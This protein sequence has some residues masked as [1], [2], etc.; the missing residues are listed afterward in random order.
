MNTSERKLFL[1]NL[2]FMTAMFLLLLF[3]TACDKDEIKIEDASEIEVPPSISENNKIKTKYI[4]LNKS[5]IDELKIETIAIKKEITSHILSVPGFVFPAP[6]NI[7][8]ISAPLDGRVAKIYAHEGEH[9]KRGQILLELESYEYGNLV[10]EYLQANAEKVYQENKLTRIKLLVDKKISSM[11]DLDKAEAEFTRANAVLRGAYS[12]LKAVGTTENDINNL[13][14]STT[15]NSNLKIF[16]PLSGT[17]DQHLIEHGQ[18]V[19]AYDKMLSIIDLSKV[20]VRG[21]VSP[22]DGA[23]VKAGDKIKAAQKNNV[24]NFIEGNISTINPALDEINKSIVINAELNTKN[25][26]PK[27]GE[28]LKVEITV[29]SSSPEITIPLSS[30]AY[31]GDQSVVFVKASETKFEQRPIIIKKIYAQSAI[32]S[33]G[34]YEDEEIAVNQIFSLKALIRFEDYAE[35]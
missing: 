6:D 14:N 24:L 31:D 4:S 25:N 34:L 30:V 20:L 32:V 16:A 18:S 26:W 19:I 28:N 7:S 8:I 27:P 5:Q 1:K 12:K 23:N 10:A 35:E 13:I 21:Y 3:F 17:I 9:V 33:A 11:S 29:I 15:I 22:D 2:I